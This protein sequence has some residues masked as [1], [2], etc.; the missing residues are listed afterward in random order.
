[1]TERPFR[2]G[3]AGSH[4]DE[5]ED[6]IEWEKLFSLISE[7]S[8]LNH[9]KPNSRAYSAHIKP[10]EDPDQDEDDYILRVNPALLSEDKKLEVIVVDLTYDD[11]PSQQCIAKATWKNGKPKLSEFDTSFFIE[12]APYVFT[13]LEI[14]KQAVKIV[15]KHKFAAVFNG[16][17]SYNIVAPEEYAKGI[18]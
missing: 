14:A 9:A 3:T 12:D 8:D 10:E 6:C 5:N 7:L 2:E 1:M 15:E 13:P 18:N 16:G 11:S 17:R 4:E